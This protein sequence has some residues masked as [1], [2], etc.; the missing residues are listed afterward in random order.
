LDAVSKSAAVA[1]PKGNIDRRLQKWLPGNFQAI[2]NG[3]SKLA[4]LVWM[5]TDTMAPLMSLSIYNDEVGKFSCFSKLY[6]CNRAV[7][8]IIRQKRI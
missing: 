2:L 8:N 3:I 1:F 4:A 7:F 5:I 6:F